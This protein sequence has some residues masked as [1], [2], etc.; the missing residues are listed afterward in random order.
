MIKRFW[1]ALEAALYGAYLI[2]D[3]AGVPVD[4]LKYAAVAFCA[5]MAVEIGEPLTMGALLCSLV[6]DL[7]LLF[8]TRHVLLGV[9]AF[10]V[11]Q[12]LYALWLPDGMGIRA[13]L[14]SISLL[15]LRSPLEIAAAYYF[16]M[17]SFNTATAIQRKIPYLAPGLSLLLA[18]DIC[19][20]LHYIRPAWPLVAYGMWLF[21]LPGQVC[22]VLA[23]SRVGG[24]GI[25]ERK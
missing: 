24:I 8:D 14:F 18:C 21:Y 12:T 11:V 9:L 16:I 19:V 15:W 7:F 13:L 17:L 2:G 4:G 1:L 5:A 23:S 20:G 3:I 10:G 25:Y 22:L 6:A